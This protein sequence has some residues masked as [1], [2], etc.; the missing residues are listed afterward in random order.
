MIDKKSLGWLD[1]WNGRKVEAKTDH[2][3]SSCFILGCLALRWDYL[4]K[5]KAWSHS[6][7]LPFTCFKVWWIG[8]QYPLDKRVLKGLCQMED[9]T[10]WRSH[11][12]W[13]CII[14]K[15]KLGPF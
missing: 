7:D 1:F 14:R 3:S 2:S 5:I 4:W 11:K 9:H 15:T 10:V 6:I 13:S 12:R 8:W